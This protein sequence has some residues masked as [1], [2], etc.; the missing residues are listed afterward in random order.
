MVGMINF[1]SGMLNR[2]I[3]LFFFSCEVIQPS[4]PTIVSTTPQSTSITITWTQPEGDVVDSYEITYTFQGP[5]PNAE[6]PVTMTTNDG[7]TREYTVTGLEEFSDFIITIT[8]MNRAGRSNGA[9]TTAMTLSAGVCVC[10]CL[11]CA[12]ARS[13]TCKSINNKI[14]HLP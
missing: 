13:Y 9:S 6:A 8:A 5:C 11:P 4:S 2:H 10:A 7:T 12:H 14:I 1:T 3:K